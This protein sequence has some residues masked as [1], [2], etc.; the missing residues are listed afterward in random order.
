MT[1]NI[2]IFPRFPDITYE[3]LKQ[4]KAKWLNESDDYC[5]AH[6]SN[7][8]CI[9]CP[10]NHTNGTVSDSFKAKRIVFYRSMFR[11]CI[12]TAVTNALNDIAGPQIAG[13]FFRSGDF[14][15]QTL[16]NAS[17]SVEEAVKT[18][19]LVRIHSST[20]FF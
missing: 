16:S 17:R 7:F 3:L 5:E 2:V 4:S 1:L 20:S 14:L 10:V 8:V 12:R 13:R 6:P 15:N 19:Q 11:G 9:A 18:F